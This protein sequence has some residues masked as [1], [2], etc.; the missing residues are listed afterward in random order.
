MKYKVHARPD[1]NPNQFTFERT[2]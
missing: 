2:W 1:L